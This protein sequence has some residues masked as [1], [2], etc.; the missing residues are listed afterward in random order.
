[1]LRLIH[2]AANPIYKYTTTLQSHYPDTGPTS[3][4]F[5]LLMLSKQP[6]PILTPLVWRYFMIDQW[7]KWELIVF[8]LILHLLKAHAMIEFMERH[9]YIEIG[10]R[11]RP[12]WGK[13]QT[14]S[15][16]VYYMYF[17]ELVNQHNICIS[18]SAGHLSFRWSPA[19]KI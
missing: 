11:W 16:K 4:C 10:T 5:I 2:R 19:R 8:T 13:L 9:L 15:L 14:I 3:P 7:M 12:V 18:A 1:M 17:I 6:V